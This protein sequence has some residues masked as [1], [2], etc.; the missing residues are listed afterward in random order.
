[1]RTYLV[2]SLFVTLK[3]RSSRTANDVRVAV[4]ARGIVVMTF[5]EK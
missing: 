1:M 3:A 4:P 5:N 2:S